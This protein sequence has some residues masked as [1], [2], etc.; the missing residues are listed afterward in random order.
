MARIRSLSSDRIF[1]AYQVGSTSIA[2]APRWVQVALDVGT[3]RLHNEGS[4]LIV[5]G[6]GRP[7]PFG[8]WIVMYYPGTDRP[9]LSRSREFIRANFAVLT[10]EEEQASMPPQTSPTPPHRRRWTIKQHIDAGHYPVAGQVLLRNG[11]TAMIYTTDHPHPQ[12]PIVGGYSSAGGVWYISTWRADG[13]RSIAG[14]SDRDIMPPTPPVQRLELWAVL[15]RTGGA[16]SC[17]VHDA[18]GRRSEW[19]FLRQVPNGDHGYLIAQQAPAGTRRAVK[20]TT[21][22]VG[23]WGEPPSEETDDS[24]DSTEQFE[25]EEETAIIPAI[26]YVVVPPPVTDLHA[27]IQSARN[28]LTAHPD[29]EIQVFDRQVEDR[30]VDLTD[31]GEI[32]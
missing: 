26:E 10:D 24:N 22:I 32:L 9:F 28:A 27:D 8:D 29:I 15:E 25:V 30:P 17:F 21:E 14:D 3:L 7:T 11:T 16:P 18:S 6:D 23:D 5:N 13:R 1:D 20:W 2:N 12:R 19:S 31:E 4:I